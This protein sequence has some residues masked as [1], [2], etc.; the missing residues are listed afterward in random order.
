MNMNQFD[1][2]VL[3]C[4][5]NRLECTKRVFERIREVKPAKLYLLS[6]GPREKIKGEEEKVKAVRRY[7]EEHIDW[8]CKIFKNF[9]EENMGCG[10]RMSSGISWAFE[11]EEELIIVEDDC[12]PDSSFFRYCKELLQ[13]YKEDERIMLV[14]GSNSVG[15]LEGEDS[16]IFTPYVENW[17]W[18]TWKRTW[19]QYDYDIKDWRGRNIPPSMQ[20]V[21]N[22][23]AIKQYSELFD[24]VYTHELDTWDYQLQYLVFQKG[25]LTVVP[26]KCLVKNIGFGPDATHT[27]T[28]PTKLYSEDHEMSFPLRIPSHVENNMAYNKRALEAFI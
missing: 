26:R 3:F 1:V 13:L 27:K 2:P 12:L 9:A 21:M 25:A 15:V 19:E 4:T 20:A 8:N 24:L 14:G 22:E 16:F 6:D 28:V 7:L 11:K 23:A 10:R 5:F 18:A 17:G